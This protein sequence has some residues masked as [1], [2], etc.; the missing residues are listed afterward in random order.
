MNKSVKILTE[1]RHILAAC[2]ISSLFF[3]TIDDALI[4]YCR[5]FSDHHIGAM[6]NIITA[7]IRKDVL[8][9]LLIIAIVFVSFASGMFW[10]NLFFYI[11]IILLQ[12]Y[13]TWT[14]RFWMVTRKIVGFLEQNDV[15]SANY[16]S[17]GRVLKKSMRRGQENS[18][19]DQF[20]FVKYP[21]Q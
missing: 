11:F 12:A 21:G 9:F 13:K 16:R 14:Y 5:V 17:Y 1:H 20:K 4:K 8:P 6:V 2:C 7:Y 18:C 15:W 19:I 10:K 3:F